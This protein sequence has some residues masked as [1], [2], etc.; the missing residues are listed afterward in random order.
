MELDLIT[1]LYLPLWV[2]IFGSLLV[3]LVQLH[4]KRE[5]MTTVL[6]AEINQL[7]GEMEVAKEYLAD[8]SHYWLRQGE[9]I[10][11]APLDTAPPPRFYY[12]AI[13]ELHLLRTKEVKKVFAF[14]QQYER[15]EN[16]KKNLF[17]R[18]REY[19][20]AAQPLDKSAIDRLL[21][22][23]KRVVSNY[24]AVLRS[25]NAPVT[26]IGSLPDFYEV[27]STASIARRIN[28]ISST[29]QKEE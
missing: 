18:I 10:S 25:L 22:E 23:K 1:E 6:L 3:F 7:L 24:N 20:D 29:Q 2:L 12:A 8:D 26:K 13:P 19:V 21:V 17:Q 14:Y 11:T 5:T 4:H 27:E 15:T 9:T 28:R 16:L